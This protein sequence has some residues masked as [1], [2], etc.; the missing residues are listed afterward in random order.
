MVNPF[1]TR[2]QL[3]AGARVRIET[4]ENQGTG[5][6]VDGI[7]STLLTSVKSHPHG[8][9]VRLV[10][11]RVGRVKVLIDKGVNTDAVLVNLDNVN[12]PSSEDAR[13]EFK[14]F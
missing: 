11:G 10:D 3:R 2:D 8:I 5:I 1:P 9:K 14:E 7:I 13:H 6:L 12:I 4:K